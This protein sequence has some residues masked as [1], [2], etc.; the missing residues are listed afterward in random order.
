MYIKRFYDFTFSITLTHGSNQKKIEFRFYVLVII[1]TPG[2]TGQ[3]DQTGQTG[4]TA[5][6][7]C[8]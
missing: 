8:L 3:T 2:Q 1:F 5:F 4:Q 7:Y 6:F